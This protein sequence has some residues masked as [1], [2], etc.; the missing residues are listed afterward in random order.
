MTNLLFVALGGAIGASL[1]HLS[2]MAA[3]RLLGPGFPWGTLIVNVLGS[4]IMGLFIAWMV[5]RTGISNEIRLFVA[6]GILGGFT[7]FSAFSLDVANLFEQGEMTSAAGYI[8]ASVSLSV[9]AVFAGLWFGRA[10]L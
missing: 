10:M 2:G 3:L 8:L 1:R 9:A 7:T 4:L 6:T 5:K